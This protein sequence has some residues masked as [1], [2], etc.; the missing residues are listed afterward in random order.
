[1]VSRIISRTTPDVPVEEPGARLSGS[2][3]T[4]AQ[5]SERDMPTHVVG[6]EADGHIVGGATRADDVAARRVD[7]VVPRHACAPDDGEGVLVIACQYLRLASS[8]CGAYTVQM[9]GVL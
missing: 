2:E 3:S 4:T 5:G 8:R 1:V 6:D 9:E 7:E